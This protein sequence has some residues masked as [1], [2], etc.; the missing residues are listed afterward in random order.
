MLPY[1][2]VAHPNL[3]HLPRHL[4][5][6]RASLQTHVLIHVRMMIG[7]SGTV[8]TLTTSLS[9]CAS[10]SEDHQTFLIP[11]ALLHQYQAVNRRL[12]Q[13]LR[14]LPMSALIPVLMTSIITGSACILVSGLDRS[15]IGSRSLLT[16]FASL[17]GIAVCACADWSNQAVPSSSS[18]AAPTPAPTPGDA[19]PADCPDTPD[20]YWYCT[21]PCMFPKQS[22]HS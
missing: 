19:R 15:E 18:S 17:D 14:R 10:I 7:I 5:K 8:T 9:A 21:Y 2:Q 11:A 12:L 16:S 4:D 3:L 13:L 20:Y 6:S 22:L 1:H